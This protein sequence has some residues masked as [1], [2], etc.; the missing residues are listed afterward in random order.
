MRGMEGKS[1]QSY[2]LSSDVDSQ[3]VT[4]YY[5][6]TSYSSQKVTVFVY[7]IAYYFIAGENQSLSVKTY[8]LS[9]INVF[10]LIKW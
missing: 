4:I 8:W 2:D 7:N 6:P 5:F 9:L 1:Q 10:A 3:N